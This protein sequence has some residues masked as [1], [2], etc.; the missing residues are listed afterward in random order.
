MIAELLAKCPDPAAESVLADWCE[1]NGRP[2]LVAPLRS[3]DEALRAE[4]VAHLKGT[5]DDAVTAPKFFAAWALFRRQ[6]QREWDRLATSLTTYAT[7]P[8]E[9]APY[10]YFATELRM[11][12]ASLSNV[13]WA[14][15]SELLA[16]PLPENLAARAVPLASVLRQPCAKCG[17]PALVV[18]ADSYRTDGAGDPAWT[19]H[20]SSLCLFEPHVEIITSSNEWYQREVAI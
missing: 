18:G 10:V 16:N 7:S 20:V 15:A 12:G 8:H 9:A 6:G 1:E 13:T 5:L 19:T 3:P 4:A 14:L 2:F 11:S 17:H